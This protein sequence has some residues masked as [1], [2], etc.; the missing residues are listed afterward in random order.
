MRTSVIP[1]CE[2]NTIF[3]NAHM[4]ADLANFGPHEARIDQML[5]TAAKT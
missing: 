5:K 3:E 2:A 1:K 4:G